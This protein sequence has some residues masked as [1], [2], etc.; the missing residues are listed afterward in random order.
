MNYLQELDEKEIKYICSVIPHQEIIFY[1][2]N[3]PKE[4]SKIRPG[5]RP[6]SISQEYGSRILFDYRRKNFIAS[7]IVKHI[8]LWMEQIGEEID[9]RIEKDMDFESACIEVLPYSYFSD[10]VAL[11][12]KIKGEKKSEDYI[13]VMSAAVRSFKHSNA[14]EATKEQMKQEFEIEKGKLLQ[15]TEKKQ[16]MIDELKK[17]VK[18]RDAK[19]R[20][21]QA[22]L[23]EKD[24]TIE[25]LESELEKKEEE[26]LQIEDARKA[27]IKL[28]KADTKK[29][30]ILEQQIKSL[31]S[32]KENEWKRKTSEKRQRE[33]RASQRQE[34]PLRPE[35]MDEFEEYFE[36][37][38]NSIG[39]KPEANLKR[40]FLCYCE[41]ILFDGTPILMKQSAAKN[42]SACL[43]NT[44][45]G[46][47]MVSTL[48]Y[49]T[50]IT[51]ERISDFLIQSKDRVVCLDGFVGNFNEIELLALLSEFRDKIIFVTYIYDGTLQYMPTSVMANFNY[52]SLDRIESFS[53]IM[54]LSEDP[55]ILKEVMYKVSEESFSNNRY[56][57]ICREI[58]TECGLSIRDCGRYMLCICDDNTLS[59]VLMF[60]IL[61][62]VRDITLN[63]PYGMSSRLRKYAGESGRC[64]NKDILMEWFG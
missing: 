36:Y 39:F 44:I 50:G 16:V 54:D 52:I 27:A 2:K 9:A 46:K 61:P 37:N 17:S 60:T 31:R 57:R 43:L 64:Q 24:S 18:D 41:N 51:T 28:H 21:I 11:Y 25:K 42:L 1:F 5:F 30:G 62:Y 7:F 49:T 47:R 63:N 19:S 13:S 26:R 29:L 3:Y 33:L 4:F 8:D 10:N 22:Q 32:E 53:K 6:T 20:K 55:S 45:Q 34:R 38:L 40:A 56:K 14:L 59:A 23:K 35:S 12:F 48:L 58:V 15:E